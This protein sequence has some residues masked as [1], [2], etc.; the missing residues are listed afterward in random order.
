MNA[1]VYRIEARQ[2]A[3]PAEVRHPDQFKLAD[4]TPANADIVLGQDWSLHCLDI[5][6]N[7]AL[8][9]E[10]P[11]G[12]D[13]SA[14]PFVFAA[15]FE[16]AVR[17]ASVPLEL[18][19]DLAAEVPDPAGLAFLMSTGRCGSTLASRI[20]AQIPG[21]WSLSE[22]DWFTNLAFA[23]A[24]LR[25]EERDMLIAACTRLTCRPPPGA[26]IDTIVLKPRSEM[27]IQAAAYTEA[28]AGA[29]AVFL[30]RDCFGYVNS[31]YRFA[32]RV[33][34]VKDPRPGTDAWDVARRLSTINAPVGALRDYFVDG[35]DIEVL[36][37]MTLGWFL[38][39]QAYLRATEG[40]MT[41]TP[42]H[43]DDLTANRRGQAAVLLESFG[44]DARHLDAALQA[45]ET[46]AHSGSAGEN[47][48]PSAPITAR[49]HARVAE[50]L[51]R[52]GLPTYV[53]ER[54]PQIG[55]G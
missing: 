31:L 19:P 1:T 14:A 39:M 4:P 28:F 26:E 2:Q 30:Y 29:N 49:Q 55:G 50:L 48:V 32:Q 36:D 47:A 21:V 40:G 54:L 9:V 13:L 22:P 15:Q 25:K 18:L 3:F 7:R 24:G 23:R 12:S 51:E 33:Q 27:V 46:D 6:N 43:Y 42:V 38:R 8:F 17:A 20:F 37:L 53:S 52:W 34:G 11:P 35:E 16:S 41:V 45:F 10:L 44:I 5:A